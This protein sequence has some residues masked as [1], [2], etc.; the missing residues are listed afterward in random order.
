M[1]SMLLFGIGCKEYPKGVELS[2]KQA[3]SNKPE[4]DKVLERYSKNPND[5]LKF[6]AALFLIDHMK[7]HQGKIVT[8]SEDLWNV[9]LIEDSLVQSKFKDRDYWKTDQAWR[10]YK[11]FA[12]KQLVKRVASPF[13][14]LVENEMDVQTITADFLINTIE[15]AFA[16]KEQ[17]W[18]KQLSFEEFCEYILAYR[19]NTEPIFDIRSKLHRC[20]QWRLMNDSLKGDPQRIVSY[21]NSYIN[22]FYWDWD[23]PEVEFPDMGFFNIFY[24]NLENINCSKHVAIQGQ[25]LRSLGIPVVEVFTSKWNDANTGHSWCGLMTNSNE[26]SLFSAIYEDPGEQ[27]NRF[28]LDLATKFFINTFAPNE[29][30]PF[31]LRQENEPIPQVFYTPCFR[32]VTSQL[33]PTTNIA[34]PLWDAQSSRNLVYFCSFLNGSWDPIGWGLINHE[35]KT[36]DFKDLPIGLI[37]TACVFDGQRMIPISRL[38]CTEREGKYS[39]IKPDGQKRSLILHRKFPQKARLNYFTNEI[40]GTT[41]EGSNNSDFS[42]STIIAE[43]ND[44]LIPYLQDFLFRNEKP[45]RYYRVVSPVYQLNI[46]ELEFITDRK[47]EN[48]TKAQLLPVFHGEDSDKMYYRVEG[49]LLSEK[50]DKSAFDGDLLT[51]TSSKWIGI[52]LDNPMVLNRIRL[53]PRNANNGIVAGD[54]YELLYWDDEWRSVGRQIA[55]YNYLHF[56]DVPSNSFYWLRNLSQGREEQPFRVSGDRQVFIS[57]TYSIGE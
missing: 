11:Y 23:E 53:A 26:I 8:E 31:F 21:V 32:D 37:G 33:V 50:N 15:H 28:R 18:N 49:N 5:S 30:T 4:L 56:D 47:F 24:W 25:I 44:T 43:I 1:F 12:K 22:N 38:I 20:I 10:G 6:K 9:F 16:V 34:M 54:E 14:S 29:N 48:A 2:L 7:W 45:F 52:E 13:Q 57:G 17:E 36:V 55:K 19:F 51:F 35:E 42:D 41:I 46:A 39:E 40:I 3:G 27:D